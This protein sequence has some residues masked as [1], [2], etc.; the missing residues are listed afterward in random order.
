MVAN[1]HHH[2]DH[3][4]RRNLVDM[5]YHQ[6]N[7]VSVMICAKQEVYQDQAKIGSMKS[8]HVIQYTRTV[9]TW[10]VMYSVVMRALFI[11]LTQG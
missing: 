9:K 6:N 7:H 10:K 2:I 3:E 4:K 8:L 11:E 1:T 5:K